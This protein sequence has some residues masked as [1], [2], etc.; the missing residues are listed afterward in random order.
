MW[1]GGGGLLEGELVLEGRG[2]GGQRGFLT[3]FLQHNNPLLNS[4]R[5]LWD[6]A[7]R[8]PLSGKHP[9]THT[10]SLS[11]TKVAVQIRCDHNK[12]DAAAHTGW[13]LTCST[14]ATFTSEMQEISSM[15]SR[16]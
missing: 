10:L 6:A 4:A 8:E 11:L 1:Q 2:G 5:P 14:S 16:V 7:I 13:F 3:F 9:Q 12:S 15:Q